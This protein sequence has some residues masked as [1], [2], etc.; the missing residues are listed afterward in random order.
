MGLMLASGQ[1]R[2]KR[3]MTEKT[4][5]ESLFP[6]LDGCETF[7]DVN[8]RWS[9]KGNPTYRI[10]ILVSSSIGS[11]HSSSGRIVVS[12]ACSMTLYR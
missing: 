6:R 5:S 2:R 1:M 8:L 12:V 10:L 4:E 3:R 7:G 11:S 9:L